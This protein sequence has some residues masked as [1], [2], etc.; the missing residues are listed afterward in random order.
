MGFNIYEEAPV[1]QS[2]YHGTEKQVLAEIFLQHAVS[3]VLPITPWYAAA[4]SLSREFPDQLG[5]LDNHSILGRVF[6]MIDENHDGILD[7]DE[8]VNGIH[9][10]LHPSTAAGKTLAD[11]IA[12]VTLPQVETDFGHVK[13]V[14]IIG[15][16]VAGLQTARRLM[17]IGISCTIFE[18]SENVGGVW[19]KNYADFGL[20]VPK[21]LFEFPDFP[22]PADFKCD[23]FPTGPEVQEYIELYAKTFGLYDITQ[24][25]TFVLELNPAG[26]GKRGW[27]VVYEKDKERST[28]TFDYLVVATGMYGWPPHIPVARGSD[29][30]KG[31]ILHSC[32]FTDRSVAAGKKVVVVGGGKSAV[33]NAVSAAKAG[34]SS[35]LVCRS[36]HWPVPR[37][38]LDWVPFK[39]ATY[40]R[41][42]HWFVHP[43]HTE[44]PAAQWLHGTCAPVKWLWW[45][46]VETMFRSQFKIPKDM[47]PD[48][49]I[50]VD[51]FTGGQILDY[52]FRDMLAAGKIQPVAGSI[53]KFTETGVILTDGKELEAD[54]VI[55]GTGFTKNYDIFDKVIQEKLNIQKDGLYL[56]R[57]I[58]PPQVPDVAFIGCEVATFNNILTHG[59]QALWLQKMLA[60]KMQVPK[61]GAME[62]VIE[63]ERAWKRSWMPPSSARACLYQLHM[64][65][66]HDMLIQDTGASRLRKMPNCFGEL[67]MPITAADFADL[68]PKS[69]K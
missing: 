11:R 40:N 60:G 65:K 19:Q 54:I 61:P 57:N 30:F 62:K 42:G 41:F 12:K 51:L 64:T 48:E 5:C 43:H 24:F 63:K 44:G 22:Y 34:V 56:Y 52:E 17:E 2:K 55:Y 13:N 10:L 32:T 46:I 28:K 67:C 68:F 39:Y 58:I 45:R 14:A 20:Q 26:A 50:D 21:E 49:G 33:D 35:T 25:K 9:E 23:L 1:V 16:G 31:Q 69:S 29:K 36:W 3:G 6:Q 18:K 27:T 15:A 59:L 4:K 47:I 53:D 7:Q 8:F 37:Y 66:Y 38:L